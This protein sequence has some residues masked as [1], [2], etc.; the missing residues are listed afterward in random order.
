MV[1]QNPWPLITLILTVR[2]I[3]GLATGIGFAVSG[4]FTLDDIPEMA[5][6]F[7]L[8]IIPGMPTPFQVLISVVT[9]GYLI[10]AVLDALPFF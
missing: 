6:I 5:G 4:D 3:V 9:T 1:V 10:W 7:L 8:G 2:L